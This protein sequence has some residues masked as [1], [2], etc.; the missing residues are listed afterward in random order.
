MVINYLG[1]GLHALQDYYCHIN[2]G[3]NM[4]SDDSQ[5]SAFYHGEVGTKADVYISTDGAGF[6]KHPQQ[7]AVENLFDSVNM[8]Y[9]LID[10]G[11]LKWVYQYS[12][13]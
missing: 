5:V 4:P 1:N 10:N 8:D 11:T 13:M 3:A 7:V 9:R 2:A 12:P 6:I